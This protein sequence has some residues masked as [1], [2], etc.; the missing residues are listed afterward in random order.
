LA[1][2]PSLRGDSTPDPFAVSGGGSASADRLYDISQRVSG[3]EKS[4]AYLEGHADDARKKLDT[5]STD[6]TQAK[7]TFATLKFLFVAICVGTWGL[8]SA[9]LLMWAKHHFGL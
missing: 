9:A 8:F 1:T 6:I 5:I 7:A 2:P 3:I 4:V